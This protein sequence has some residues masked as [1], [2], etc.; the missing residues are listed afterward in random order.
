MTVNGDWVCPERFR[1]R[2]AG[3]RR[4][5]LGDLQCES[6]DVP[7][8]DIEIAGLT[9]L[10]G[11]VIE[12]DPTIADNLEFHAVLKPTGVVRDSY[13]HPQLTI[14]PPQDEVQA[15]DPRRE[16]IAEVGTLVIPTARFQPADLP[17]R[18]SCKPWVTAVF[19]RVLRE[20][21]AAKPCPG[22]LKRLLDDR[23]WFS[24][25]G[26]R[27]RLYPGRRSGGRV[28]GRSRGARR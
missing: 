5:K 7:H 23:R 13:R 20:V 22:R 26:R 6:R 12:V 8:I 16:Q 21:R 9:K 2:I 15:A 4:T 3:A 27:V 24:M 19:G 25:D 17:S 10:E 11:Y 28:R 1:R 18:T 14:G